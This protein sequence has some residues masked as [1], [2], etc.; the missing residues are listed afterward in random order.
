MYEYNIRRPIISLDYLDL[1]NLTVGAPVCEF[2]IENLY[3]NILLHYISEK[4]TADQE[5][6]KSK[7]TQIPQ[8]N[9]RYH[10]GI[11]NSA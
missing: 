4:Q 6:I 11:M 1:F 9:L 3:I 7:L 8:T 10:D 2:T 5:S